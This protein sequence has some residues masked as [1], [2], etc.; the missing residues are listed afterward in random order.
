MRTGPVALVCCALLCY[1]EIAD[2]C[3][4]KSAGT[5]APPGK[6]ERSVGSLVHVSCELGYAGTVQTRCSP[7]TENAGRWTPGASN[8]TRTRLSCVYVRPLSPSLFMPLFYSLFFSSF[9]TSLL[10]SLC[11]A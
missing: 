5:V 10:H 8:C 9:N 1:A 6:I 7:D 2:Y 3:D 4:D 11:T